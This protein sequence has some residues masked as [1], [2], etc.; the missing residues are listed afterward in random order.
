MSGSIA[1]NHQYRSHTVPFLTFFGTVSNHGD[2][3][4]VT[5]SSAFHTMENSFDY[6]QDSK[7]VAK[8][9]TGKNFSW[10]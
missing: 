9:D 6:G 5:G 10:P 2:E 3:I 7:K 4:D 1:G 8:V